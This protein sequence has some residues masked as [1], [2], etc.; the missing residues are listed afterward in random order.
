[1]HRRSKKAPVAGLL[2]QE[3]LGHRYSRCIGKR[4]HRLPARQSLQP[5][6]GT[7]HK[8]QTTRRTGHGLGRTAQY[9]QALL[10]Q[11][12]KFCSGRVARC[13]GCCACHAK[14]CESR[15]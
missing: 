10:L 5:R 9:A 7:R 11:V 6:P 13:R 2:G 12:V 15:W 1:M 14:D 8:A 3:G 4:P